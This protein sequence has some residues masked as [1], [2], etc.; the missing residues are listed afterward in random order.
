MNLFQILLFIFILNVFFFIIDKMCCIPIILKMNKKLLNNSK[1]YGRTRWYLLHIVINMLTTIT[2]INGVYL[3]YL[4]PYQSLTPIPFAEPY[5]LDWFIGPTSPLPTLIVASG[6]LYHI[7]FFSTSKSDIYHHLTF[8]ATMSS[9]NMIGNYGN[10]R[11]II[12]FVLSG[13]PGILEYSIMSLYKFEYLTKKHMRYSVTLM[14]CLLR[15]PLGL[16][17]FW[18]LFYQILYNPEAVNL[19]GTTIVS[20]LVLLNSTQYCVENIRSSIKHYQN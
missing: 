4:N 5:N 2:A 20:L 14:H 10:A 6:H 9:I 3:T 12:Q 13:L 17:I 15:F 1:D 7:L 11:N 19:L 16:C 8:A 18:I